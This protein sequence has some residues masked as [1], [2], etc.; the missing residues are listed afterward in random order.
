MACTE[1]AAMEAD[2]RV[3]RSRMAEGRRNAGGGLSL[4]AAQEVSV[5]VC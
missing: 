2:G 4:T 5:V 3:F 1:G